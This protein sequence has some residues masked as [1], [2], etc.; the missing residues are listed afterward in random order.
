ME[1]ESSSRVH[2]CIQGDG[3]FDSDN[4]GLV[5]LQEFALALAMWYALRQWSLRR[6]RIRLQ[7]ALAGANSLLWVVPD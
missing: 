1:V 4:D 5:G 2:A 3:A 6:R 7:H